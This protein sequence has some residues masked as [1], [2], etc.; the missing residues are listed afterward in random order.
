MFILF[1]LQITHRT[2]QTRHL[3][4]RPRDLAA[5]CAV[6]NRLWSRPWTWCRDKRTCPW[7]CNQWTNRERPCTMREN[8]Y[9]CGGGGS[10]GGGVLLS[11]LFHWY[12]PSPTTE[13]HRWRRRTRTSNVIQANVPPQQ[14]ETKLLFELGVVVRHGVQWGRPAAALVVVLAN[15]KKING[16]YFSS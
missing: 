1:S 11:L 16:W 8:S 13:L 15:W 4:G 14:F 2:H 6:A 3:I 10:G 5:R 12:R 9:V 7:Q